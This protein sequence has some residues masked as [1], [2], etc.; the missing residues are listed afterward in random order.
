MAALGW[1]LNLGFAGGV[2]TVVPPS[3]APGR[4]ITIA[5][6]TRTITIAARTRTITIPA[7][8]RTITVTAPD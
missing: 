3:D 2:P 6:R 8:I 4:I 7:R 1:L 5:A